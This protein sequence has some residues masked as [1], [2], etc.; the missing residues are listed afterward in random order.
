MGSH[1]K[2]GVYAMQSVPSGS[3]SENKLE[4]KQGCEVAHSGLQQ[5]ACSM[6]HIGWN[7]GGIGIRGIHKLND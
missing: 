7:I 3:S 6:Q 1:S 4:S 2:R 5:T